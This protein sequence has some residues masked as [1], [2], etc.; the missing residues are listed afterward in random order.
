[1]Q[2]GEFR[3]G[4][5]KDKEDT[6]ILFYGL[7][8][9]LESYL[10]RQWTVKDVEQGDVFFRLAFSATEPV[11]GSICIAAGL[12]SVST[13]QRRSHL[14]PASSEFAYPKQLFL[15]FIKE[16]NGERPFCSS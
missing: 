6:R 4:F 12:I 1:M 16:H 10:H 5:D 3:Q 9:V 15:E 11:A 13:C 8:Y 14:A 2:Y 7:R